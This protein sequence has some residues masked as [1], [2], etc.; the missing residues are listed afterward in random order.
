MEIFIVDAF[1][2]QLFGGNQ[3]GVV[4]LN[5]QQSF[6]DE[7]VMRKIAAEVK[8]SETAFVKRT[9]SDSF[10]IR[11]FTPVEEVELCGH[12]TISAFSVLRD[13]KRISLG[14]FNVQT[15]A[16]KLRVTVEPDRVW[17]QMPQAKLIRFLNQ[18]E[19]ERLYRAYGLDIDKLP[20]MLNPCIVLAGLA[21]ILLPVCSKV[22]LD[23]A[24]QNREE[25]ITI[26]KELQV[27]GVHMYYCENE[28]QATAYCRNFAPLVGI[29]EEAAT[30]T[31]N[32]G[33][34]Y[35]LAQQNFVMPGNVNRFVQG[36]TMGRPSEIL[37]KITENGLL[38]IGGS[39]VI[40]ITGTINL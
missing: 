38:L 32:A 35:Y 10:Q 18:T 24:V 17:L 23:T 11:Y 27:T 15:L 33:L 34:T 20:T 12:A 30:G 2:N 8:H 36:E 29:D 6:P 39:A 22:A 4:L 26:S 5:E 40:S 1:T 14:D 9:G 13:E 28:L 3:A 16:G 25:I 37:S 7:D 19:I 21:D 31:S